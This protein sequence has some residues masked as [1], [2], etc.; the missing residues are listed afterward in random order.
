[1]AHTPRKTAWER[2]VTPEVRFADDRQRCPETLDI[3]AY[4]RS[5]TRR[6]YATADN[7]QTA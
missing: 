5:L 1:M 2:K 4:L 7:S 6:V 3:E